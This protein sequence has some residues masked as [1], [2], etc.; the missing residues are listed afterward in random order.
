M[1]LE[2]FKAPLVERE[3]PR[4]DPR[5]GEALVKVLAAGVCGSD[6]H[7]WQGQDPRTPR[8][9]IL[10]H[11]GV[12][13]IAALGGEG[14]A[15]DG[16]PLRVG[17]RISWN[18]GVVCG[19]CYFC[20]V[21]GQPQFCPHRW[22][23]GIHHSCE[24][25]PHLNGCYADHV[26]LAAGTDIFVLPEALA[27][28]PEI[29]VSA[30]CSGATAAHAFESA[31]VGPGDSVLVQGPGPLGLYLVAFAAAA[32][33][34]DIFVIGGTPERLRLCEELGA[35]R[36]LNRNT[37]TPDERKN[38]IMDVTCGRGVDVAFEAV[39]TADAVVEGIGLVRVGGAYALAGFG[40]PGGAVELD[41]Y[42][43]VVRRNLRLQGVWV[44]H[45]R[46]THA[47][48]ALVLRHPDPFAKLVTRKYPL[49][50][51][52]EAL[53]AAKRREGIKLVLTP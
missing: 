29:A 52:T 11:E 25:P 9:V 39:G 22:V 33:A 14:R 7:M 32:G 37:T 12:G 8:P 30:S 19:R 17:Q 45:T 18:R 50:Q 38:A 13:E 34:K 1:V 36:L 23:Y 49:R 16:R 4:P 48:L 20:A 31:P 6:V 3:F 53:E 24:K 5:P 41:C 35:T 44:S 21:K 40:Q 27:K 26:L 43:D 28:R 47:A 46:H 15:V 42:R 51:A 10:G 2:R